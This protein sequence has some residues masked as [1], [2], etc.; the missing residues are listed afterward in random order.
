M[1]RETALRELNHGSPDLQRRAARVLGRWG[2]DQVLGAL[3][4]ALQS[5]HRG[6][7]EAATDTL[8]EIGDARTVRFLVPLLK[9]SVPAVRNAAR[10]LLQ[11]L[12]KA[13]PE[14]L[15]ELSRDPDVR[16]R[17]FAADIMTESG[18]HEM[19]E[20]LLAL[21]DDADENVRD[22]AVV[23]LGRLGASE[24]V[25]RLEHVASAGSPWSKFSAIDALSQIAAPEAVRALVRLLSRGSEDLMEP[26]IEA[27][28]RQ[29]SPEAVG[30]LLE[31]LRQSPT[32]ASVIVPALVLM[33]A[34]EVMGRTPE[35]VR[36]ALAEAVA[37]RL[38]GNGI[39]PEVTVGGLDLL[40]M[41]GVRVGGD[42]FFRLL[43]SSAR[44]IQLAAVRT[45]ARLRLRET[46]PLLRQLQVQGDPVLLRDV[47]AALDLMTQSGKES[48]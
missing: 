31:K 32:L 6:I 34:A 7:R 25:D 30:P 14:I 12:S 4:A 48:L 23:G 9:S 43:A 8:L 10:L 21:L 46:V 24:A 45:V 41:L 35:A 28:G 42:L 19:A 27:L 11:R 16:M 26:I 29:G 3:I 5:P 37:R 20:P 15:V 36:P 18:D 40:G 33:P 13:A 2:D 47:Q 44:T 22:A 39:A 38:E 17:I 1:D